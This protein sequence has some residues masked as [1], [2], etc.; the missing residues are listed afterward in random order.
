MPRYNFQANHA[1]FDHI[2]LTKDV[3]QTYT[4]DSDGNLISTAANAEQKVNATYNDN[5]DLTSYTDT[6]GYKTTAT[7]DNKHNLTS[8]KSPRGVVTK[9]SYSSNG[10]LSSTEVCNAGDTVSIKTEQ[11]YSGANTTHG[12]KAGAYL[13]YAYDENDYFTEYQ[14]NWLTGVTTKTFNKKGIETTYAYNT[15]QNKLTSVT[16]A[17]TKVNYTYA[18]NRLSG[19]TYTGTASGSP[20]ESY[21]FD[22][23]SYG[24]VKSTKVGGQTLSTNTYGAKNGALTTVTY[25]NGDK[26]NHNYNNLGLV[27]YI[28]SDNNG[29]IKTSYS[30]GYTNNGTTRYHRDAENNLKYLYDY[31]SLGRLIRQEIQ[32]NT[33][34]AHV[35]STEVAYDVRNNVTKVAAEFDG[36]TALDEYMY[37][38]SSGNANA[39]DYAKDNLISRYR[40]AGSKNVDYTYDSLNRL[41]GK[42]LSTTT[43]VT[44]NYSYKISVRGDT[45]R[46]T[47][48]DKEKIG[49]VIYQHYYDKEG[50]ITR[51]DTKINDET[52][53]YRTYTYDSKNQLTKEVDS[54]SGVTT[55]FTYDAIGNIIQKKQSGAVDKTIDY[56]YDDD[57][58]TGWSK[59]LTGVDLSDN[60]T[61][62]TAETISY[63]AIGNPTSYLGANLSWY[64]RQLKSYAKTGTSV[65]YTYD[66]DGLRGTKTVTQRIVTCVTIMV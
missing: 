33:T 47:Q 37:S 41:T 14:S 65:S 17:G 51:I 31:D 55:N 2:Q 50:N 58:K 42:T 32:N 36:Y 26:R 16:Q 40:I 7:Y 23:D 5:N 1:Y 49:G 59:L 57:G 35:G 8:S 6:A 19:I 39:S 13:R 29:A 63:D 30:W 18:G 3:A 45:Y 21:S 61:Y 15:A 38:S 53:G 4:Y 52:I 54:A 60:G 48:V 56:R 62:E 44:V 66:A 9:N 64:G 46:T 20:S 25:G 10:N 43:P 11:V 12:I 34:L 24:N 28:T 22:Y 27:S